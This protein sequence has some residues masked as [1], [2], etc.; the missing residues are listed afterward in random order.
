M[1]ILLL[2]DNF[3]PETNSPALRAYEH[4]RQWVEAG[5]RVTVVTSIPNFPLGRPLPPYRNQLYQRELI[6][7]INVVRVWTLMAPNR[8]VFWRSLDFLS[9][10]VTGFCAGLF[11][12]ADVILA[13]SPQ[14][15]TGLGG[16]WVAAL[17]RR[18]WIFEVRDL[19]PDSIVSVG[20]MKD[21]LLIR[22]LRSM[23]QRLYRNATKVVAVSTGIRDR[24]QARGVPAAKLEVVPNGVDLCSLDTATDVEALRDALSL[25]DKF[26][27]GY[28]GTHGMAQGLEVAVD[29]AR[30]LK[31][32]GI[33]FLFVGEGARRDA[34]IAY[35]EK[36]HL[37]NVQFIGLVSRAAAAD[38]LALCDAV[39]IPLRRTDQIHITIPAKMFEAAAMGKPMI[40][41]AVGASAELVQSYGAGI[42][43]EP[44]RPDVLATA[45]S[46]LRSATE[47]QASFRRGALR[48][49]RD[50]DRRKFA[51][52]MLRIMAHVVQRP[53]S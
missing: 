23:E 13:S 38:H 32:S 4:A 40:V 31:D 41:S 51:G 15:L 48:M 42:V 37:N 24:L 50:Y 22:G 20:A 35:A 1:H 7:G 2:T 19:W 16:R 30:L 9:F 25:R 33:H 44:E 3:V 17:K 6:E 27:V 14:L 18:P 12:R 34:V 11:Q 46:K 49:A 8:G 26:V 29:A 52:D 5:H 28:V 53:R 47:M 36:L 39:L 21:N 43:V 45:I 10:A